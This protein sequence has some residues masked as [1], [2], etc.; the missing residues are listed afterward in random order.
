MGCSMRMKHSLARPMK[1]SP[2]GSSISPPL[3]VSRKPDAIAGILPFAPK[4]RQAAP[5]AQREHAG[6][7][8]EDLAELAMAAEQERSAR[9]EQAR[10]HQAQRDA[11]SEAFGRRAQAMVF[12]VHAQL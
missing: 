11:A 10:A 9:A 12:G 8:E 2:G 7:H 3:K 4:I 1:C 5:R 6:A